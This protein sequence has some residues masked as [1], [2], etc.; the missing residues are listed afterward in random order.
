MGAVL[1]V[2]PVPSGKFQVSLVNQFGRLKCFYR[3]LT[4][5]I[6]PCHLA[7]FVIDERHKLFESELIAFALI[8]EQKRYLLRSDI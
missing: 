7:Q 2:L 3:R 1:K 4:T 8:N 5:H 6:T